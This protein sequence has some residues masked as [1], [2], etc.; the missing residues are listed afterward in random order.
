MTLGMFSLAFNLLFINKH[1]KELFFPTRHRLRLYAL[2][3][4]TNLLFK[5]KMK[6]ESVNSLNRPHFLGF[7]SKFIFRSLERK[8]AGSFATFKLK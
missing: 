3:C 1:D 6:E 5:D 8:E 4:T 2:T 7:S